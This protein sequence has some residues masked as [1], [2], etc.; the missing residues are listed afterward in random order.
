MSGY[1]SAISS[2]LKELGGPA[3]GEDPHLT[4][5]L[6]QMFTERPRASIPYP[7]WNLSVVLFRLMR[8]PFEPMK[9][10]DMRSLTW[11]TAFLLSLAT[12]KRRSE[13]HAFTKNITH[14]QDWSSVTL[15]VSPQFL[16]KTHVPSRPQTALQP[17]VLQSLGHFVGDDLPGDR[18]LCPVRAIK[19][20]LART[21]DVRCDLPSY[22][23]WMDS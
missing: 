22:H 1:R 8:G 2:T 9:S 23:F 7:Q 5:L 14:A 16:S 3:L 10:S 15:K 19:Y 13:L 4:K 18:S 12:A 21:Q 6:S 11:K 17:V 20:Y